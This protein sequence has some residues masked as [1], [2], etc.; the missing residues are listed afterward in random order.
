[1]QFRRVNGLKAV[2]ICAFVFLSIAL[3]YL[4]AKDSVKL[5][6]PSVFLTNIDSVKGSYQSRIATLESRLSDVKKTQS[7]HGKLTP[8]GQKTYNA[9]TAQISLI[10][11]DMLDNANRLTSKNDLATDDHSSKTEIKSHY[12]GIFTLA[13]DV[14]LIGLLFFLEYYDFRSF[15]EFVKSSSQHQTIQT[16]SDNPN[17]DDVATVF[18]IEDVATGSNG[19]DEGVLRLAMKNARA[20]LSAYEAKLRNNDGLKET[21]LRGIER[22][23]LKLRELEALIQQQVLTA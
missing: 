1:M 7:W 15:A 20:N 2:T 21:N 22:W 4:G 23:Q 18:P 3:S 19:F 8:Q 14:S 10:E 11:S 12:F 17:S 16:T 5:F 13:L 9:I 6:T